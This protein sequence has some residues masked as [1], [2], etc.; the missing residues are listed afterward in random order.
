[1]EIL[2]SENA[3]FALKNCN[4][5]LNRPPRILRSKMEIL[6][7][8]KGFFFRKF[9]EANWAIPRCRAGQNLA[10]KFRDHGILVGLPHGT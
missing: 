7:S 8:E 9:S 4:G 1:M 2:H 10:V 5:A 6:L 3:K